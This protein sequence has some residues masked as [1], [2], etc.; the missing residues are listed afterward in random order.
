MGFVD[1]IVVV[2]VVILNVGNK[3]NHTSSNLD[4]SKTI[5]D[6]LNVVVNPRARVKEAPLSS[7]LSKKLLIL[8]TAMTLN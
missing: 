5:D 7:A 1:V 8:S 4:A 6:E 2:L 3:F